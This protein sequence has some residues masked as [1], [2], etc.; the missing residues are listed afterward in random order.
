MTIAGMTVNQ[1]CK[2]VKQFQIQDQNY[3]LINAY[4]L[5]LITRSIKDRLI[6]LLEIGGKNLETIITQ[7]SISEKGKEDMQVDMLGN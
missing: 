3:E 7:M 5:F 2:W 1:R 4:G 6:M